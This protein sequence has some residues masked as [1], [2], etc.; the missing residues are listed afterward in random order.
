[1]LNDQRKQNVVVLFTVIS[2]L[3]GW[4]RVTYDEMQEVYSSIT[5]NNKSISLNY[6]KDKQRDY[7]ISELKERQSADSEI[8]RVFED[9][10]IRYHSF[11]PIRQAQ[12]DKE[13]NPSP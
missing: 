7:L 12:H 11:T 8:L 3:L 4:F 1:M 10:M 6:E 13:S 2:C 5:D 9:H